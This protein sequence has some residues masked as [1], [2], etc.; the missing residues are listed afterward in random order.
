MNLQPR[1]MPRSEADVYDAHLRV[2]MPGWRIADSAVDDNPEP[3]IWRMELPN[4]SYMAPRAAFWW[5]S[6]EVKR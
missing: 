1:R 6:N 5:V 3:S 2:A 4:E